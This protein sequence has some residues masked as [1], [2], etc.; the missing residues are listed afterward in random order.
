MIKLFYKETGVFLIYPLKLEP[1]FKDYIWGGQKLNRDFSMK[2]G[3]DKTAEAWLLS[4]HNDGMSVIQNGI[5]KNM[6][7]QD[8]IEKYPQYAGVC[9][10][11]K[12]PLIIKLIDACDNLSVQVHPSSAE[13]CKNEMWYVIDC[14]E[15]SSILYGIKNSISKQQLEENIR[16]NTVADIMNSIPVKKGDVFYIKAGTLHAIGKGILIAEIQQNSNVTYRVFDY[17]RKDSKGNTRP[18]HITQALEC[19]DLNPPQELCHKTTVLGNTEVLNEC[20]F[21]SVYLLNVDSTHI[22][23]SDSS[24]FTSIIILEGDGYVSE[25][26]KINA[27]H[28]RK[29]DSFFLSAGCD[30]KITGK[31]KIILTKV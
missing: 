11:E 3:F 29:G 18:L 22:I 7:L 2:S 28:F 23:H 25:I 21:F 26:N 19:A 13:N 30:Y 14:E 6:P 4:C 1:V 17:N 24:S 15:N 20:S 5:F 10:A 31:S 8:F 9:C 12:F 27:E 16:N